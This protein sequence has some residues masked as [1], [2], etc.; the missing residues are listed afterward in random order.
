M[1]T[2]KTNTGSD[3]V[4]AFA[5]DPSA[6]EE[7]L[8]A[9]RAAGGAPNDPPQLAGEFTIYED[10]E[11]RFK[12]AATAAAASVVDA[13]GAP[14]NDILPGLDVFVHSGKRYSALD[15]VPSNVEAPSEPPG[16]ADFDLVVTRAEFGVAENGALW[17][18]DRCMRPRSALFL[19]QHLLLVVSRA[20]LV[21]NMHEA[22][23]RLAF[24]EPS[25]GCFVAG[26]S[27][28][29]DIE[30]S[31]VIGAHGPRSLTVVIQ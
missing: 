22:V 1:T 24:S 5:S 9:L 8:S 19:T 31:L 25:Y 13:E 27:K 15:G 23:R 29:A 20:A 10:I 2:S 26:P 30:Q 3:Q 21:S 14:L 7:I 12:Q 18:S 4:A 6:R 28:T 11:A 16:A 17:L